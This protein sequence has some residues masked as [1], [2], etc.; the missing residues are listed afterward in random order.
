MS[1]G[2]S[3]PAISSARHTN[4]TPGEAEQS[5][6]D[7]QARCVAPRRAWRVHAC[8]PHA[9]PGCASADIVHNT[10]G[11]VA[12]RQSP[13]HSEGEHAMQSITFKIRGMDCA[14][15]AI[16][17]LVPLSPPTAR[18]R[19]PDNQT[20][21]EQ[22]V[23]AIPGGTT[24]LVRLGDKV[25]LDGAVTQGSTAVNHTPITG[26]SQ[27]ISKAAGDEVYDGHRLGSI[28]STLRHSVLA[29][30]ARRHARSSEWFLPV[31]P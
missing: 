4:N 29:S 2:A 17:A 25:P 1:R 10:N 3:R 24:V 30:A 28:A 18:C 15:R 27:P 14:E 11:A 22:P 8:I 26:E 13:L 19:A 12:V 31:R 5:A 23:A 20:I 9:S 7:R 21:I 16:K 6:D